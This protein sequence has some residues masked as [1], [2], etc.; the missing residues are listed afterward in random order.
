MMLGH[1]STPGH[2]S[3]LAIIRGNM[4]ANNWFL[5]T[6]KQ[7]VQVECLVTNDWCLLCDGIFIRKPN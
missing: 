3:R 4:V 2:Y 5:G 7:V 6:Q 1:Y